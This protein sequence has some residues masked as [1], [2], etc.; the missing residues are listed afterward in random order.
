M[1]CQ[2]C[3]HEVSEND[4]FCP[5]C[6]AKIKPQSRFSKKLEAEN[7]QRDHQKKMSE[8]DEAR[9]QKIIQEKGLKNKYAIYPV[10]FGLAGTV[11][12]LWPAGHAVQM[13]WW[14]MAAILLFGALGYYFAVKASKLNEQYYRRYRARVNTKLIKVGTYLSVF[15]MFAAVIIFMTVLPY[16][17]PLEE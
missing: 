7:K 13:Q 11:M 5:S 15:S 10:I 4:K 3:H 16:Y 9:Q 12:T 14:Y 2:K 17:F 1:K 6:G 8:R